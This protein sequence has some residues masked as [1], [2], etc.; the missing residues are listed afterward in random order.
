[1]LFC[2]TATYTPQALNALMD[3]PAV[4]RVAAVTKL[5][6]AAGGKLV[7]MYSTVLDGPGVMV[8][9]DVPDPASAPAISGVAVAS[10]TVRDVKLMR[11]L[12]PDEV[13]NV[14]TKAAQLR[15]AYKAAGQ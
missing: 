6:E 12:T 8:I 7:A 14:R 2:L 15:G 9:F 10:G 5:V 1:M 13:V 3:N 11:L 4:S